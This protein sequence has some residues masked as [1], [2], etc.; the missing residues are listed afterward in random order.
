MQ[1][2]ILIKYFMIGAVWYECSCQSDVNDTRFIFAPIVSANLKNW[3]LVY[4]IFQKLLNLKWMQWYFSNDTMKAVEITSIVC[5]C[6]LKVMT[7]VFYFYMNWN[8]IPRP[9]TSSLNWISWLFYHELLIMLIIIVSFF[10]KKYPHFIPYMETQDWIWG[11]R[12]IK[13]FQ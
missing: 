3:T 2:C 10:K 6:Y 13:G 1:S 12:A 11:M 5:K 7:C 8:S 4:Y 9:F